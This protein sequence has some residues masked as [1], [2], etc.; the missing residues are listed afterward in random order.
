MMGH[1]HT[2][3][4]TVLLRSEKGNIVEIFNFPGL[5]NQSLIFKAVDDIPPFYREYLDFLDSCQEPDLSRPVKY[6][7]LG[8]IEDLSSL[9]HG[10][11][12]IKSRSTQD[13]NVLLKY[14]NHCDYIIRLDTNRSWDQESLR[15]FLD[16]IDNKR[17]DY[18]EEPFK[19][20]KENRKF[21]EVQFACDESLHN[22]NIEDLIQYFDV[23]IIKLELY[24]HFTD[25][26]ND[27][28][29]L[30]AHGK[31][32]VLSS[33]F[34]SGPGIYNLL[35]FAQANNLNEI[36][37]LDTTKFFSE[38]KSF[39][40]LNY[41]ESLDFNKGLFKEYKGSIKWEKIS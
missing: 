7:K 13:M 25:L 32:I 16:Q 8:F 21:K 4:E 3:K 38:H 10:P 6:A 31:R 30:K 20:F 27:L 39:S 40:F 18:I 26:L 37:G 34:Y 17:I 29:L 9:R 36:H 35:K 15:A 23:F 2:H 33:L 5:I 1:T 11:V 41:G 24:R 12:K 19:N 22:N 28:S 14:L